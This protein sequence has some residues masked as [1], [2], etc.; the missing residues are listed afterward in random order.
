MILQRVDCS[1]AATTISVPQGA[2]S[3]VG[4]RSV[5][6]VANNQKFVLSASSADSFSKT[7]A[8]LAKGT[9]AISDC[10]FEKGIF[11]VSSGETLLVFCEVTGTAVIYYDDS[12]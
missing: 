11:P 3:I 10:S 4:F 5:G 1:T 2:K 8:G 9:I 12:D 7:T 6:P